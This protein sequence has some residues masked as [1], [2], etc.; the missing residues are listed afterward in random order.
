ML[1]SFCVLCCYSMQV[2][3]LICTVFCKNKAHPTCSLVL[4]STQVKKEKK[5]LHGHMICLP[6]LCFSEQLS[7]CACFLVPRHIST[8]AKRSLIVTLW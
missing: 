3:M 2:L 6:V 1:C 4:H 8:F 7:F 5:K